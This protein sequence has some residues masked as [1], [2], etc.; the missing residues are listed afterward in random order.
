MMQMLFFVIEKRKEKVEIWNIK[1]A[2]P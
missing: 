1:N 2:I